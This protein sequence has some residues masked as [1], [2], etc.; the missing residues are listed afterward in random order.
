[1]KVGMMVE[2]RDFYSVA[3]K[4]DEKAACSVEM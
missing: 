3:K 4:A 2:M 1:M